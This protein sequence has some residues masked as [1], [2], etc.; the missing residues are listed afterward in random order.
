MSSTGFCEF[1]PDNSGFLPHPK[2]I[3]DI[4]HG[5]ECQKSTPMVEKENE[6]FAHI[7]H[8]QE[9]HFINV[10]KLHIE[11][12][13]H[14][15]FKEEDDPPY[16]EEE[17]V[18]IQKGNLESLNE[19]AGPAEASRRV[20]RPSGSSSKT[21]FQAGYFMAPP[22]DSHDS[23][24]HLQFCFAK[25]LTP[26]W[27]VP[28]SVVVKEEL[29]LPQITPEEP[30]PSQLQ[31]KKEH[32]AIKKEED[33][34][35]S[36]GEPLKSQYDLT[37]ASRMAEPLNSSVEQWRADD[38]IAPL[39]DTDDVSHSPYDDDEEDHNKVGRDDKLWNCSHCGKT[40]G[41]IEKWTSNPVDLDV[42]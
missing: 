38:L 6:E 36:I 35:R 7:K 2:R 3:H 16:V 21:S 4:S 29:E 19:Y 12:E 9:E 13:Q 26:E 28:A 18:D 42:I 8:E 5:P 1:S 40:F 39:S 17:D 15:L 11:E 33:V 30:G 31:E 41:Q 22:P 25:Y 32:F 24:S 34:N 23:T 20:E 37:E 10:G 27:Q 14:L